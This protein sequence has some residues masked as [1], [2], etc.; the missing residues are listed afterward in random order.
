ML[1]VAPSTLRVTGTVAE[2]EGWTGMEFPDSG[3]HV[4]PGALQPV[5]IDREADVGVYDDP[6]VWMRHAI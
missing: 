2:W 3:M 6:N 1:A 5:A 4:V